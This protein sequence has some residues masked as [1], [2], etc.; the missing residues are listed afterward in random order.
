MLDL[1]RIIAAL[2][3]LYF[4]PGFMFVQA[5]F[6][7]KGELDQDFD[8]LYRIGLAIG[9]SIVLTIFV[10]FGLNSLGVSEETGLG[11][12][13]AGPIVAALLLLS[14]II[15]AIAWFRGG[16]PILGRL[17]PSLM[18]FPPR[19]PRAADIPLIKD[20]AKRIE[21]EKL[22]KQRFMLIKEIDNTEK[23]VETHSGKQ[24][25]YYEQ[26]RETLLS[27]LDE[28]ETQIKVLEN[29]VRNG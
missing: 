23:L 2:F 15:F 18:R 13:S 14:L 27:E 3:L 28:I 5:M 1:L 4:L 16:F 6:P 29:E 8:W 20:K 19:D 11:Y 25:Q 7:R 26:R 17:H 10:G 24:H 12:V 22:V 9:L 21:H